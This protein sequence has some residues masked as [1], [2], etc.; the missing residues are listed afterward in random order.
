MGKRPVTDTGNLQTIPG[1]PER[2][3]GSSGPEGHSSA[4][5]A[6]SQVRSL[7]NELI[8]SASESP[9]VKPFVFPDDPPYETLNLLCRLLMNGMGKP[10]LPVADTLRDINNRYPNTEIHVT[11]NRLLDIHDKLQPNVELDAILNEVLENTQSDFPREKRPQFLAD[12]LAA[13]PKGAG[14]VEFA[15]ALED[16]NHDFRREMAASL[17]PV[18]NAHIQAMPHDTYEEKKTISRWVNDELRRFDLAIKCPKTGNPSTLLAGP[19]RDAEVGRFIIE[20]KTAEGKRVRSFTSTH[21]PILELMEANPRREVFV[22][23]RDKVGRKG[24]GA[25]VS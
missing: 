9:P 18:L 4:D 14:Y 5:Q 15:Q 11:I 22:E 25:E 12:I 19:F 17:A 1:H 8:R 24:G 7:V 2:H 10:N 23:W 20:H 13:A 6:R 21:L 16:A 3:A